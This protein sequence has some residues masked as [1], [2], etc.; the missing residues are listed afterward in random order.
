M[1]AAR[2]AAPLVPIAAWM[3][4]LGLAR[5]G[6]GGRARAQGANHAQREADHVPKL[7][8]GGAADLVFAAAEGHSHMAQAKG[9]RV[10]LDQGPERKRL[11]VHRR[12]QLPYHQHTGRNPS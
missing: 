11:P 6:S 5:F 3:L 1:P 2:L 8:Q 12:R 9:R 7:P 10:A 4:Y